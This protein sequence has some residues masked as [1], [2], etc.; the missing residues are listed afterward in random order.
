[1]RKR[2]IFLKYFTSALILISIFSFKS[3]DNTRGALT[4]VV[5]NI[6]N[7]NGQI[8][9]C[10]FQESDGFPNHPEK[11]LLSVFVKVTGNSAQY[12]FSNIQFGTYAVCVFHDENSD[13][14]I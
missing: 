7:N 12:T 14:K 3:A 11:A 8:G 4:V 13:T 2:N 1:M 6:R 5:N 10:L 9:F